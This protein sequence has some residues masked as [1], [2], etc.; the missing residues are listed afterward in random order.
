MHKTDHDRS[1]L[2]GREYVG[3]DQIDGPLLFVRKTHPVGYRELVEVD[4]GQGRTRLG[5]AGRFGLA[6]L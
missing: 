1:L 5:M 2:A 3:V 4:D 6:P